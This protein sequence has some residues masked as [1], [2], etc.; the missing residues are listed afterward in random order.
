V[1]RWWQDEHFRLGVRDMAPVA[2]G[3]AAWGLMT[4]VATVNSGLSGVEVLLMTLLPYAGSSQLASLPL[5]A[6]GAPLWVVLA[7]AFCVN[8]RFIVFSA[9]LRD[10][11]MDLPLAERLF[12]GYVTADLSYMM[13]LK[14]WPQAAPDAAGR[15]QQRSY[16]AGNCLLGWI[17]WIGA[18]LLGVAF[19]ASIP[20]SWGLGF[21]GTLALIGVLF[22]LANSPLRALSA[23]ISCAAA[24]AAFALPLRLNI[25]VGIA[26][27]VVLC[28]A[29]EQLQQSEPS[30][31]QP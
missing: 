23:A 3:M 1:R 28:L 22:S 30:R 19:A 18:S 29:I 24:V 16:L 5:I 8:L 21:A 9:H 27:A 7:T 14:H 15:R 4:G 20:L 2:P 31:G 12:R 17:S 13:M 11:M 6:A 10:Y 25:L 26:A